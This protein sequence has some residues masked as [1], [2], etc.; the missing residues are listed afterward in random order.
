MISTRPPMAF[1]Q[2]LSPTL[3]TSKA[4]KICEENIQ[5]I[6]KDSKSILSKS[7][8]TIAEASTIFFNFR[9]R[10]DYQKEFNVDMIFLPT[11]DYAK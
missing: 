11:V 2:I 4:I 1:N 10:G 5:I 7:I 3:L 9:K 8:C 6:Y